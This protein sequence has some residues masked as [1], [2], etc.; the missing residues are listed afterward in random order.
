MTKNDDI[1]TKKASKMIMVKYHNQLTLFVFQ[2]HKGFFSIVSCCQG[3]KKPKSWNWNSEGG[4]LF[5]W[6]ILE[7]LCDN[8]EQY[9]RNNKK[10]VVLPRA[11]I[12]A[13]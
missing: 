12:L 6:L 5:L 1:G 9:K 13:N 2:N 7:F 11:S 4:K 8:G 10:G 3:C